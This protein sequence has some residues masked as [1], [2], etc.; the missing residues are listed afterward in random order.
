MPRWTFIIGAALVVLLLVGTVIA[1][2][3]ST[4]RRRTS[5]DD[6]STVVRVTQIVATVWAA[7]ASIGAIATV[8]IILATPDVTITMPVTSFWPEL[9]SGVLGGGTDAERLGGGFDSVT[10]TLAGLSAG[11]RT[12][13]AISQ[14]LGWLLPGAI[15]LLVA[16]ACTHLRRGQAF[17]PVVARVTMVAAAIVAGGGVL[18]QVLGDIA[19]SIASSEVF[20]YSTAVWGDIPGVDD[21]IA[22][23][24]PQPTVQIVFPLWPIAAGLALAA[25]AAIFRYGSRLQHE[26]KGLV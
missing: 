8:V 2:V 20:G 3:V 15:A 19:G 13:W 1:V 7:V 23:W 21:P 14:A 10:L 24:L 4:A 22:A 11:A 18:T 16:V 26:V 25:L 12:L 9:P 6:P 5:S 17:A